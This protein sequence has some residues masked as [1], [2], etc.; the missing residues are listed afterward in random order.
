MKLLFIIFLFY[1]SYHPLL[2]AVLE[3]NS[4]LKSLE[5]QTDFLCAD[6]RFFLTNISVLP[7]LSGLK[8][9]IVNIVNF[10]LSS[11]VG[12]YVHLFKVIFNIQSLES[13]E[14]RNIDPVIF[15]ELKMWFLPDNIYFS[16]IR[17]FKFF[18]KP[19][20]PDCFL[21]KFGVKQKKL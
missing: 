2:T 14:I 5:I 1:R 17:T 21:I 9:L 3:A 13:F 16:R 19:N 4:D 15:G 8:H 10:N 20:S 6:C 12:L 7:I 18:L 11:T